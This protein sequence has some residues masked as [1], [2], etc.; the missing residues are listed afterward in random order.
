VAPGSPAAKAGIRGGDIVAQLNGNEVRLGGDVITAVGGKKVRTSEDL[1]NA[2]AAKKRGD[3]VKIEVVHDGKPQT[4]EV[5]L[6]E[7]PAT[8]ASGSG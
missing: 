6:A 7:R 1:A 2:I 5:T 3:K 8:Q 4:V